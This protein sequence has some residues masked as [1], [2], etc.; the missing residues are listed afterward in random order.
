[1]RETVGQRVRRLR[2][3]AGL[4]QRDVSQPGLSFA[5]IS[6]VEAGARTPS[7]KALR[8]LAEGLGVTPLYLETGR[9][10]ARCPWCGRSS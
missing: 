2:E 5:Y 9:R 8:L 1:M 6:R 7:G 3:E 4:S 10:D